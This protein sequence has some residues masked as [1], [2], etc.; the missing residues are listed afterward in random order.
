MARDPDGNLILDHW[1]PLTV[2]PAREPQ[3]HNELQQMRRLLAGLDEIFVEIRNLEIARLERMG[4]RPGQT[5]VLHGGIEEWMRVA[6][7][8]DWYSV[9]TV[10]LFKL[11]GSLADQFQGTSGE[12]DRKAYVQ[13]A[14]GSVIGLHRNKRGAHDAGVE[15]DENPK[16]TPDNRADRALSPM[17]DVTFVNGIFER[18]AISLVMLNDGE[19]ETANNPIPWSVSRF[20]QLRL[21]PRLDPDRLTA[22]LGMSLQENGVERP[23][24]EKP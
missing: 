21:L 11:I 17:Q 5:F 7:L 2:S 12:A 23:A 8:F 22:L 1:E 13:R 18:G 16:R 20:H 10:R 15:P 9:S 24:E 19:F 14:C 3:I 4:V 6:N